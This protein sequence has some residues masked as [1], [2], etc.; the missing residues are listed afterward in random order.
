MDWWN[1]S[2]FGIIPIFTV[3]FIFFVKR[4]LLWTAPFIST[5]IS[6]IISIVAMP[7]ILIESEYR[8]L[9]GVSMLI[10]LAI[11]VLL[12]MIA[13]LVA[14]IIRKGAAHGRA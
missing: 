13:Y 8:A 6:V 2:L 9:F 1:I 7:D 11:V 5:I 12:T 3:V 14:H 4:K 10:H